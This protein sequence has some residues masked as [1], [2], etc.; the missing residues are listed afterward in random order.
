MKEKGSGGIMGCGTTYGPDGVGNHL[1]ADLGEEEDR[2]GWSKVMSLALARS[3]ECARRRQ[4]CS[5]A[6]NG[7]LSLPTLSP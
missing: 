1:D 4:G 7:L 6:S 5:A 2:N 3:S